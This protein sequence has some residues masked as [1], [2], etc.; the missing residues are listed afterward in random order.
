MSTP[1]HAPVCKCGSRLCDG[2]TQLNG[3]R[4]VCKAQS[5]ILQY[6][7]Q[8]L[9]IYAAAPDMAVALKDCVLFLEQIGYVSSGN[10]A[11][12]KARAALRKAGIEVDK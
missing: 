5:T 6:P 3:V 4:F 9:E 10:T 1:K 12:A 11:P 7:S 8:G 2:S